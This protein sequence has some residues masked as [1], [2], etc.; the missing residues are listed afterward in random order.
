MCISLA[1]AFL[2]GMLW[3][4]VRGLTWLVGNYIIVL[5]SV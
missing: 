2:L 3:G 4:T 5:W 1:D